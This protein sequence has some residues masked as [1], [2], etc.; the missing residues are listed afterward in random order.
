VSIRIYASMCKR[1]C[2][3]NPRSAALNLWDNR[4]TSIKVLQVVT[5]YRLSYFDI[6][7]G[8]GEPIRIALHAAGIDFEDHRMSFPE[9]GEMRENTPFNSVPVLQ[10]DGADISQSNSLTRYV[11]KLGGLY[12]T[13]PLQALYCDEVADAIEDLIHYLVATFRL[14]GEAL[15]AAREALVE[16]QI[17]VYLRGLSGLLTRGGGEYFADGQLTV[18]DL[19]CLVQ[20]RALSSGHLDHIPADIVEQLA[21]D[22]VTHA[23][24]VANDA[25]VAAYYATRGK[26]R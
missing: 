4:Q 1:R 24:R 10:I 6:D 14:Q 21:P 18:A 26:R 2:L 5:T 7:G 13:D 22:L 15:K 25:R 12:P 17:A 23:K 3:T 9:F 19:K 11:G 20:V 8:R 16:G